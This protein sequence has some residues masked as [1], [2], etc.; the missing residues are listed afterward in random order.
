MNPAPKNDNRYG[1]PQDVKFCTKCVMPN[2]RPSS[3]NEYQHTGRRKHQYIEFDEA[4]V[5]SACRFC[6]AKFDGTIDWTKREQELQELC[7]QHRS[8]DGSYDCL[9]PGSGGK[10]S[11]Y[12]SH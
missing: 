6:A 7:D 8:K 1:L 10:D 2:T 5:C 9:V 12:A 4:G 11:C 3:C